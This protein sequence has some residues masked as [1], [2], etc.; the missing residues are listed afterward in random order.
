MTVA[1]HE[2]RRGFRRWRHVATRSQSR[3]RCHEHRHVLAV[4]PLRRG[5]CLS[6][7][8]H[9]NNNYC[10]QSLAI[11]RK[12]SRSLYAKVKCIGGSNGTVSS[13]CKADWSILR[14]CPATSAARHLVGCLVDKLIPP[15]SFAIARVVVM[16]VNARTFLSMCGD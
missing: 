13:R 9:T 7:H 4:S 16:P 6:K 11:L 15:L 12:A 8:M 3:C 14:D 5:A 1:Q 10:S 2:A